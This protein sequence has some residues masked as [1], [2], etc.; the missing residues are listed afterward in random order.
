VNGNRAQE[1]IQISMLLAEAI[2][3]LSER[4]P[5]VCMVQNPLL[6]AIEEVDMGMVSFDGLMRRAILLVYLTFAV[7]FILWSPCVNLSAEAADTT[8]PTITSVSPTAGATGIST[9]TTVTTTFSEAM[10][11]STINTSSFLLHNSSGTAVT[12]T[13]S[14][15]SFTRR[16]T[17]SPSSALANSMTY[18]ATVKGGTS[19]ARDSAGNPLAADYTWS[20][21]TAADTMRPTVT[22]ISPSSGATGV[23]TGAQVTATFSEAMDGSTI[24]SSAFELRSSGSLVA[25]TVSYDSATRRATLTPSGALL[26]L[27]TYTATVTTGVKDVGGNALSANYVW[28]FT[29]VPDTTPP[30]VTSVS[31]PSGAAGVSAGTRVSVTFSEAMSSSTITSS[32]LQLRNSSGASVPASVSF[33]SSTSTASLAPSSPLANSTTYTATVTTGVKDL[34]GNSLATAYNWSFTTVSAGPIGD[35]PGGPILIITST[36]NP[37]SRYYGEILLAEGLNSFYVEDISALSLGTLSNYDLAILGEFPLTSAQAGMLT[38]WVNAGGNLIAMRPDGK[39]AQLLGLIDTGSSLSEGYLLVNTSTGPGAGIVGQTIQFHDTADLYTLNGATSLATLYS[40]AQTATSYPAVTLRSV[41]AGGGQAAA[42]AFDLA[43]SI[44]YTRQGNPDW[45]GQER[46]GVTPIRSDDLFYGPA[47]ADPQPNWID[48]NKVAIPQADELQRLLANLIIQINSDK[49]PLP[50]FWYFPDDLDAVIV[51]T[52]DD[53]GNDGTA[54]RFTKYYE[55]SP[56]NCSV[57]DWECIRSTSYM[58]PDPAGAL[59]NAQALGASNAGF[60]LGLHVNTGCTD[61]TKASLEAYFTQ[62]LSA[63]KTM[64]PSLPSPKTHRVHCVVWS[65][66]TSMPEVEFN[67][68][69]RMDVSYYYWPPSWVANRPGFFTGSGLPM[70]FA[71]SDGS[72]IDVFQAATQMT[73]ESGQSYPDTVISLLDKA[74]GVEGFYGAFVANIHTDTSASTLSDAIV[75][76][77]QAR[78]VPVISSLQLLTWIDARNSSVMRNL[79]WDGAALTFDLVAS[80]TARGLQAMVPIVDGY[81]VSYVRLN[82]TSIGYY[83][84]VIKGIQYAILSAATGTYSIGLVHDTTPPTVMSTLPLNGASGVSRGSEISVTFSEGMNAA[85]ITQANFQLRDASNTAVVGSVSYNASTYTGVFTPSGSLKASETYSIT[86]AGGATGVE[87]ASGNSLASDYHWSFTTTN[88]V[89]SETYSIWDDSAVP[90]ITSASDPSAVELGLKFKS[91]S[92]GYVTGI[93][94]YKGSGNTGTHIGSL[95]TQSG[96]LLGSVMFA[97]E[98]ASGWQHQSLAAPVA[99]SANQTYV[100]SYH[101]NVGHYSYTLGYFE[102]SGVDNPPL[103]ALSNSESGGNGLYRYGSSST[104]PNQNGYSTNY[105][106]DV[107]LQES[108]GP[109]TTPPTLKSVSPSSGA[110]NVNAGSTVSAT[111]SEVMDAATVDGDTF[112]LRDA[113]GVPVS[114]TVTYNSA[115]STVTLDPAVTLTTGATYTA[116]VIGGSGGVTDSAGN[117]MVNSFTWSFSIAA[118]GSQESYSI[119]GDSAVPSTLTDT[120]TVAVELGVKFRSNVDG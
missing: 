66:Y 40:T 9:G 89:T 116:T 18:T 1:A 2:L 114:A 22:S 82:G 97:S 19:G 120:D 20:F 118:A 25:T 106:V 57:E 62:Q 98:T 8:P 43:R 74:T 61:F 91:T 60:E 113:A 10:S 109:D 37:F 59:T 46:D 58:Y 108:L 63:W 6:S 42:F 99:I 69:I 68:G 41:G 70:R 88:A 101:T 107:E 47:S 56:A 93:R 26:N 53:H 71:K 7:G 51:M 105:W 11:S 75:A 4:I 17:L 15:S 65:D 3:S 49:R 50:R 73:D 67:H 39:L 96:T 12:A 27:T 87:D 83:L 30:T 78:G 86:V 29:T 24:T 102:T 13:V 28:S 5:E 77:A 21:T 14:Y 80:Q 119:W 36:S 85:T 54:G 23:S 64:Y 79:T 76:A 55:S 38:N 81:S 100:V 95:W 34:V 117:A 112:V 115:T 52:G 90:S 44:V 84:K 33:S 92:D 104:F 48:L 16:A 111:F 94:F 103:R 31:P 35:G 72:L 110:T 45:A 32:T